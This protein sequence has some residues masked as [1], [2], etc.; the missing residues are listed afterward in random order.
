M[1]PGL[2]SLRP[3]VTAAKTSR[4]TSRLSEK[5]AE[6]TERAAPSATKLKA[7]KV[8][9]IN[10][11]AFQPAAMIS[12]QL[13]RAKQ[14]TDPWPE[15]VTARLVGSDKD[16]E[17]VNYSSSGSEHGPSSNC[18]A[19]MVHEFMEEEERGKC[20]R[21]R[22]NCE[23]GTCDGDAQACLEAEDAKSSLGG[24]LSEVLQGLAPCVTEQETSLLVEVIKAIDA[25]TEENSTE[26]KD[27]KKECA[28]I[29]CR[30]RAVMKYLRGRGYNAALCKS[31]W[32]HSGS[33]PGGD[34]EYIDAVFASLDGSQARLIV[35]ID[36]QGQ[37]EIARPTAQY[38]LVYQALPP[39]YVGTTDRLSQIIN[40]MS[41]AVKR[42]LKKKGMFLPP[43][44]KPEYVKAK[45]FSSYKRTTNEASQRKLQ[46]DSAS[47]GVVPN[48][49]LVAVRSIDWD[50][51]FTSEM[52]REFANAGSRL[53]MKEAKNGVELQKAAKQAVDRVEAE[54]EGVVRGV[55]RFKYLSTDVK[56]DVPREIR[57]IDNTDWQL[58]ELLPRPSRGRGASTGLTLVLREAG[59]IGNNRI[60]DLGGAKNF[61]L[62]VAAM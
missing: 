9:P 51:K 60:S 5:I 17:K 24:D 43:W 10:T 49:S 53:M 58:P 37:F 26:G 12:P 8:H 25:I 28:S 39:V 61:D 29:V 13:F 57:E 14:V 62:P 7:S 11:R 44:R 3:V 23:S 50:K 33:F 35:D 40:V 56:T 47:S 4:R 18:L 54:L 38:K 55:D 20:G 16:V 2:M 22:C 48:I 6:E 1:M 45:W 41:E 46:R 30:R 19:A 52:E 32:D 34:Y 36:F 15:N 42:S 21:A 31:R 59:L 27:E